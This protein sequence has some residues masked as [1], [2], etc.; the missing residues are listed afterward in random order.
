MDHISNLVLQKIRTI[1]EAAELGPFGLKATNAIL[2]YAIRL[3]RNRQQEM[4]DAI[5]E[6]VDALPRILD[7]LLPEDAGESDCGSFIWKRILPYMAP[8]FDEPIPP[9]L[10]QA[11]ALALSNP[12]VWFGD[13]ELR[14]EAMVAVLASVASAAPYT[15]EGGRS[16]VD[17]LLQVA[18][19]GFLR[20]YIPIELWAWLN[21][22]PSLPPRCFGRIR[23]SAPRVV[24]YVRG[25]GNIEI[26]KS[27]LLLVWSE[28]DPLYQDGLPELCTSVREDFGGIGLW[29]NRED[30]IKRLNHIL[31]QLDQGFEHIKRGR[32]WDSRAKFQLQKKQ[33]R[34]LR[35]LLQAVDGDAMKTLN[36]ML[37]KFAILPAR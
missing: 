15:E 5:L 19:I 22:R 28:W 14:E 16:V 20:P 10:N 24:R 37:L 4:V 30:L 12:I 17:A 33:Y 36:R 27:Y 8:L 9:L 26:L 18:S 31:G 1:V 21:K 2:P 34:T 23:G 6:A 25:L 7:A 29:D 11:I 13:V 35:D 32:P 3:G